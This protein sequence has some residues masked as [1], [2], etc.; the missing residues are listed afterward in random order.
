M[1]GNA[2]RDVLDSVDVQLLL[3]GMKYARPVRML[4]KAAA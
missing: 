1:Q 4:D 2:L 3:L